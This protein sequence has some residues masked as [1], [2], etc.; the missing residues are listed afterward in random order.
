MTIATCRD[1][2]TGR[3]S[4]FQPKNHKAPF[5]S[6]DVMSL[7]RVGTNGKLML[8]GAPRKRQSSTHGTAH[9]A[10]RRAEHE[11]ENYSPRNKMGTKMA[12]RVHSASKHVY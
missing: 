5:F 9:T 6:I 2:T 8:W 4:S 12:S 10:T 3:T 7:F 1:L 11:D